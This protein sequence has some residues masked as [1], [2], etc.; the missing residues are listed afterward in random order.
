MAPD[1]QPSSSLFLD[2]SG[3]ASALGLQSPSTKN[4]DATKQSPMHRAY[5]LSI[6]QRR[7][8][9]TTQIPLEEQMNRLLNDTDLVEILGANTI[10][11]VFSKTERFI[12]GRVSHQPPF[13]RLKAG[14]GHKS[15]FYAASKHL[16][17]GPRSP[18]AAFM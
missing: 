18:M 16:A 17:M 11:E 7:Q 3:Y 13:T 10:E 14:A 15:R 9:L 8:S 6:G 1:S 12:I 5:D 2:D 4:E